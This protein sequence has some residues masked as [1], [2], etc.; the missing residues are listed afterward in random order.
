MAQLMHSIAASAAIRA[1]VSGLI[2]ATSS[3]RVREGTKAPFACCHFSK[4]GRMSVV[5][6]LITGRFSSGP[7]S[8][9]PRAATRDTCV[10]QVQRGR[11][12]TVMAQE[13]HMPTRQAKR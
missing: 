3:R 5:K 4:K 12:F 13:P 10:R 11:P 8:S 9:W 7:I 1:G 2:G 6:S